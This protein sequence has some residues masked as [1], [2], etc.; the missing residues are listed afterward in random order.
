MRS[1]T[2]TRDGAAGRSRGVERIGPLS[3]SRR[4]HEALLAAIRRGDFRDGKLPAE[5]DLAAAL[6][7]SRTTLRAA[8]QNLEQDGIV[9]R[10]R[11]IG[12]RVLMQEEG[13]FQLEL[14]RLAALDDL[15]RERGH[16]PST[17]IVSVTRAVLPDLAA[18]LMRLPNGEWHVIEKLWYAD[19]QPAAALWDYVPCDVLPELPDNSEVIGT[20][21]R[22]FDEF[23][24]EPIAL[25]RVELVPLTAGSDVAERLQ[26]K[27]GEAYLRLW[28]RHYGV[29]QKPLAISRLDI[30]DHFIRLEIVRRL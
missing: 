7:V 12:T 2:G 25:A 17:S 29:S 1:R 26:I 27:T 13:P 19:G 11:G 14:N 8:L 21:F 24:P 5:N 20:I 23:G 6:G 28:Q 30:N 16:E 18:K 10:R 15:L 3:L 22:L 9:S 4:T